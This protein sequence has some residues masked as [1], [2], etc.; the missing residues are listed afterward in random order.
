MR[1]YHY[2]AMSTNG[3][4]TNGTC[5]ATD[6][7]SLAR[8]LQKKKL[9]L[10][11]SRPA[12][13]LKNLL[14]MLGGRVKQRD[15]IEFTQHVATSLSAGILLVSALEDFEEQCTG[16]LLDVV[17]D[18]R[19]N[20]AS[21]TAFDE[22]LARH[23]DTFDAVYLSL[24]KVGRK[25]GG[26]DAVFIDLVDYLEWCDELQGQM[27]QA[28]VYPTMLFT[29][30][31]GLF[32][33]MMFFVIPR[34]SDTFASVGFEL[35][36]LTVG[37]MAMGRF[38]GHWWWLLGSGMFGA[39]LA[40]QWA[41]KTERGRFQWDRILLK[42]PVIGTFV[43]KIALS[44]FS[45]T[46]SLIFASGLD[47]IALLELLEGVVNNSVMAAEIRTIRQ[48]VVTGE[49]LKTAFADATVFPPLIQR[50]IAVGENTGS[51]D[52]TLM[53]AA[54]TYDKEIPKDLK[55]ALA[56]FD[57][58]IIAVLGILVCL[59]ALSLLMPIMQIGGEM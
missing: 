51:L 40:F 33:L 26:M 36:A 57:A 18:V 39:M 28:M 53:K 32:L 4:V 55:K 8:E 11:R 27:K 23:P 48:R 44:R 42:T 2:T 31:V 22:A 54:E 14:P 10:L 41:V 19:S 52:T 30:I 38:M 25:A 59:A 45:R 46:F 9:V 17:S 13:G 12:L 58:M 56:I 20:V 29:A 50:L 43:S 3:V 24:C 7:T 16:R 21:G 37:M 34:F 47:L 5:F 49:S 6:S 1:E 35:P 15:I